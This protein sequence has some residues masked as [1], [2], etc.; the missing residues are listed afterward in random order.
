MGTRIPS[1]ISVYDLLT[2]ASNSRFL[3]TTTTYLD[4][5]INETERTL[6][7]IVSRKRGKSTVKFQCSSWK[8][9]IHSELGLR[10]HWTITELF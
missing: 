2:I 5:D 10:K 9:M 8:Q 1:S 7:Y 3:A 4:F 6:E